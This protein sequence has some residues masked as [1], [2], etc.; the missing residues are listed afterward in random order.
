MWKNLRTQF[1]RRRLSQNHAPGQG[2]AEYALILALV[3]LAVIIIVNLLE[4]SIADVFSRL[5]Q[6][7][8]VAP[9]SLANYT[10]P[11]TYTPIPTVDPDATNTPTPSLTPSLTPSI[12]P[13]VTNTPTNTPTPSLTPACPGYGPYNIPGPNIQMQDFRCGGPDVAFVES[14]SLDG[15]PGSGAYRTDVTLQG[16][17]LA[18]EGNNNFYLGWLVANE[19]TQYLVSANQSRFYDFTLRVASNNNNGRFRL[20]IIRN[21]AIIHTSPSVAVPNTGGATTWTNISVP[22]VPML[23]GLNEVRFLVDAGGFNVLHFT[24]SNSSNPP[25]VTPTPSVPCYTLAVGLNPAAGGT[26]TRNPLPNCGG[27]RYT[28]GTA[29]TLSANPNTNYAFTNWSGDASGTNS[30]VTITMNS[31]RNVTANFGQC[32]TV[33]TAVNPTNGGSVSV[34][35]APNCG[36]RYVAGTV[37]T[38]RANPNFGYAFANWSGS[39]SGSANPNVR[40]INAATTVTANFTTT[41]T[42]ALLVVG[43][44]GNLSATEIAIRDRLQGRGYVVTV[45]DDNN[46][47]SYNPTGIILILV[48]PTVDSGTYGAAFNNTAIPLILLKRDLSV[49]LRLGSSPAIAS[50]RFEIDMIAATSGHPLAAGKTG[51]TAVYTGNG[52]IGSIQNLGSGAVGIANIVDN[53][54]RFTI[55]GY[56]TGATMTSG[57]APRARVGFF[58]ENASLYHANGWALFDAAVSWVHSN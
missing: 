30:S 53:T 55:V 32:F 11:P 3:A 24:A 6:Q 22:A 4:V 9:P 23:Q 25:T 14:G 7:A 28:Q 41:P 56:P 2:L 49:G 42:G 5:V 17:D 37:V 19:W 43:N 48:S 27:D 20:Q 36:S 57:T 46:A 15:G 54:T 12:T 10:P 31:N 29:V 38:F 1:A 50:D 39:F 26:V 13:S 44:P 16:P 33:T 34:S 51:R 35:P 8:P 18:P 58:L 21:G 40:T 52:S 45:L 47:N